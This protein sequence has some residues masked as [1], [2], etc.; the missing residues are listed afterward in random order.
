VVDLTKRRQFEATAGRLGELDPDEA[1]ATVAF[2][3][4]MSMLS[5]VLTSFAFGRELAAALAI[6]RAADPVVLAE[7][8]FGE[9]VERAHAILERVEAVAGHPE[10]PAEHAEAL[11]RLRS[12]EPPRPR[13]PQAG[14]PPWGE[15]SKPL[16]HAPLEGRHL[17]LQRPLDR[18]ALMA[19]AATEDPELTRL[20]AEWLAAIDL[21]YEVLAAKAG[22]EHG[23]VNFEAQARDEPGQFETESGEQVLVATD[24]LA[25]EGGLIAPQPD[26][27]HAEPGERWRIRGHRL[28]DGSVMPCWGTYRL[29]RG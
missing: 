27:L 19:L 16:G 14:D 26:G 25:L 3:L 12:T 21:N 7:A 24:I 2:T 5:P 20:L 22:D 23:E 11:E 10:L 18:W 9:E 15:R 28:D 29:S 6:A 1:W 13:E 8:G 17:F 4:A